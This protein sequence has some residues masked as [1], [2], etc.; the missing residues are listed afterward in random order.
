MD[1]LT[2]GVLH[3][4]VNK[5]R[6][7]MAYLTFL[8]DHYD[9]L[10]AYMVFIHAH[11][12]GWP[13]AWHV[14]SD[15]HNQVALLRSLR[16]EYLEAHG[17]ANLRCLHD[18]GCPAEIQ[19]NRQDDDRSAEHAMRD[20]WPYMFGGTREDIPTIIA[21]PC[22]SQFAVSKKQ[23]LTRSKA[24]YEHYRQ[25]LIDTSLDDATSGRVFE[26]LWQVIFGQGPVYCPDLYECG[27]GLFGRC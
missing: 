14:D 3:P 27:C 21:Q 18:P 8:I 16:L 26:Y 13:T 9:L 7:A 11:L 17:Y 6:E 2:E 5:G 24:E 10:P 4:P 1:E 25:W 19:V 22:C 20:A 12:E 23:A 15:N